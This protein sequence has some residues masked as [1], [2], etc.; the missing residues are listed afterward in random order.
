VGAMS[1]KLQKALLIDDDCLTNYI[2]Q[3]VLEESGIFE[4]VEM[5][6]TAM[7]ALSKLEQDENNHVQPPEIIFLDLN[8]PGL[9]G[10][11][12][13]KEYSY[14]QKPDKKG[15]VIVILT[16]SS[17]AEDKIKAVYSKGVYAYMVK[18][19]T[20]EKLLEVVGKYLH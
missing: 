16:S 19:L 5:V 12:F 4:K 15:S 1:L 3:I 20:N 2:N 6:E 7:E 11:D 10:W 9:D 13:I 14:F 8:M 17:N 18:P